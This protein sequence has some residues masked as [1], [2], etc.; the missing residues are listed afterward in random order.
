MEEKILKVFTDG[1]SRGNPGP[2]ACGIHILLDDKELFRGGKYL[3]VK[4][5]NIAEYS[6]LII[7]I[8]WVI[9]NFQKYKFSKV[10]F[11]MDSELIIKQ[12]KGEYKVKDIKMK[13]LYAVAKEKL[14]DLDTEYQF[15][16][17]LRSGNKIADKIVNDIL[18]ETSRK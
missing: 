18:D 16:H 10:L 3:G 6:G 9:T 11:T 8:N 13:E 2:A 5:N 12:I 15:K 17:T 7:A 1:G 14:Q 4:T